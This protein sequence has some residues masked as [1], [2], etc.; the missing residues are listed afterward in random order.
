MN[1]TNK[2]QMRAHARPGQHDLTK[3]PI[4]KT[5]L[6]FSL[7]TLA[8]NILQSL[9]G[10]INAIWIGRFLGEGALA[11]T[12]NANI[13][14]FLLFSAVFGFGMAATVMVGQAMGRHDIGAARHAF[15]ASLGFCFMLA[16]LVATLGWLG[17]PGLLRLL[18]TPAEAYPLALAY[19]RIIFLAMPGILLLVMLMMGLRGSGDAMTPLWFMALAAILDAGLNP[20]FILG[21]GPAPRM[22]ISGS[23]VAT[24]IANYASLAALI[25][26]I[27]ARDLP[28]RLR[29]HELRLLLPDL[30]DIRMLVTK[31][32]PMGLQ[33]IVI[34][35]AGLVLVGLVN[36]EGTLTTAAYG[37]AQQVWTYVQMPAMAIGGAVS[38]MAAQNVG[39]GLWDRVSRIARTGVAFHIVIT[40]LMVAL[41]LIADRP[42]LALFLGPQS[43]AIDVARHIQFLASW[44]FIIF[45]VSMVLFGVMRANGV[46]VWPLIILII[47]MFPVRLGFYFATYGWLGADALWISQPIGSLAAASMAV[48]LYLGG[49]WRKRAPMIL[50][51][52]EECRE[53]GNAEAEPAGR[54]TPTG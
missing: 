36:R 15:G 31:G 22:G 7:P 37:A 38:A 14:M 1:E 13:I 28:L 45:G 51:D 32:L 53:A 17:T 3:G 41:I 16:V 42:V 8:S 46:V 23:A 24:A 35:G 11:A 5:L 12:A 52:R 2:A 50:P 48:A 33:M 47:A 20:V 39:A 49:S 21:L 19:L 18:A 29:G 40:S 54:L 34:S 9:N 27:Y 43:P 6:L 44:S 25:A 10:S 26:Y 30:A 4:S